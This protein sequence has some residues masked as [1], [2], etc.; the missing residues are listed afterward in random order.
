MYAVCTSHAHKDQ[1]KSGEKAGRATV[2]RG[3]SSEGRR[4]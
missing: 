3:Q 4:A 2:A 1:K